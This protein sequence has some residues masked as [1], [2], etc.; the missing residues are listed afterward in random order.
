MLKVAVQL[1]LADMVTEPSVQSASPVHAL[2]MEPVAAVAVR[3]T[4][5]PEG[6]GALQVA[7]Q[8]IPAGLLVTVPLPAPAFVMVRVLGGF[9]LNVAVQL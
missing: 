9:K 5:W 6:K 1:T 2:K 3:L 8:L 4:I 7:P